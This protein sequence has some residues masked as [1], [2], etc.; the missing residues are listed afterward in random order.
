MGSREVFIKRRINAVEGRCNMEFLPFAGE[1]SDAYLPMSRSA[2]PFIRLRS[3]CSRE[4]FL[5]SGISAMVMK[6]KTTFSAAYTQKVLALPRVSSMVR[7]VAPTIML[8][9][10][11]VAV[12]T[13]YQNHDRAAAEF[14]NTAPK[15]AGRHSWQNQQ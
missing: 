4:T 13:V 6:M 7:K 15:S 10:Q 5:V 14:L 9:I 8:A 2:S 1:D 3:M 11:L 12:D